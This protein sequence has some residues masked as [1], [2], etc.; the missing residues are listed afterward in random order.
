MSSSFGG[1]DKVVNVGEH[2]LG[3]RQDCN[4]AAGKKRAAQKLSER[5]LREVFVKYAA[6]PLNLFQ[7]SILYSGQLA[8]IAA[9]QSLLADRL[10]VVQAANKCQ[11]L[12]QNKVPLCS[13]DVCK[14]DTCAIHLSQ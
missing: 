5:E 7:G 2:R 14:D 1:K 4:S 6:K 8:A 12:L 10:A 9:Y 11:S 3:H 13:I